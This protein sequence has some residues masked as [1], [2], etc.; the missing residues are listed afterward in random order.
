MLLI[1]NSLRLIYVSQ[2]ALK[3]KMN[4]KMNNRIMTIFRKG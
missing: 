2:S 3:L 4:T 1:V